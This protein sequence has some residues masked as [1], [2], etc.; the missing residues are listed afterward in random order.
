MKLQAG[1]V[2][3]LATSNRL[4]TS[5][6]WLAQDDAVLKGTHYE[7]AS[8]LTPNTQHPTPSP[9]LSFNIFKLKIHPKVTQTKQ[10]TNGE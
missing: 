8:P 2:L 4:N 1:E 3:R 9:Y 6:F 7:E 5:S 10:P